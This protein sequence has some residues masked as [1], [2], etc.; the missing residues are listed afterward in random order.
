MQQRYLMKDATGQVIE[1]PRQMFFRV[2]KAIA[3]PESDYGA[4][5]AEVQD[6]TDKF[7][8]LMRRGIFLPN[9]PT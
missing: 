4:G 6:L 8:H 7:F 2:A 5:S 3:A 1:T 9:T